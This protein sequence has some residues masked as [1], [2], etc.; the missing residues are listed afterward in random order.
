MPKLSLM[1]VLKTKH[2]CCMLNDER[3]L[4]DTYLSVLND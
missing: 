1:D 3:K 4:Y 2:T